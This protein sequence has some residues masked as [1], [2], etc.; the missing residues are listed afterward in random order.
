MSRIPL[1]L[2]TLVAALTL[3][4]AFGASLGSGAPNPCP[5]N[6][7][8]VSFAPEDQVPDYVQADVNANFLVCVYQ[9]SKK[10]AEPVQDDR[11]VNKKKEV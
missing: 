5:G 1:V 6:Y 4:L 9:G 8:P 7:D 3:T 11:V 10:N 2:A